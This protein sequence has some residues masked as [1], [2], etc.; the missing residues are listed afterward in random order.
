M[1]M[2]MK[3]LP[4]FI[5]LLF[6][7][8]GTFSSA[9]ICESIKTIVKEAGLVHGFSGIR[10]EVVKQEQTG[11]AMFGY[12]TLTTYNTDIQISTGGKAYL[13][14]TTDVGGMW[15]Y[16]LEILDTDDEKAAIAAFYTWRDAVKPCVPI[17]DG[18]G[19][20]EQDEPV[21]TWDPYSM[22]FIASRKSEEEFIFKYVNVSVRIRHGVGKG[23]ILEV[24]IY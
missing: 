7:C 3:L 16:K 10:K 19:Q 22:R 23:F 15:G 9:Q 6:C 24:L 2:K 4:G 1:Q 13:T 21:N 20:K 17:S 14:H 12:D 11:G 8:G 5:A 18:W